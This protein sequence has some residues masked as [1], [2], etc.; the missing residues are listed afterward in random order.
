MDG[1]G[2]EAGAGSSTVGRGDSSN[3]MTAISPLMAIAIATSIG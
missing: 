3:A 1:R 2:A